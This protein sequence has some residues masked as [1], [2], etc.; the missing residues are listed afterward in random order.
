MEVVLDP[1]YNT[2]YD[3]TPALIKQILSNARQLNNSSIKQSI[4]LDHT[5]TTKKRITIEYDIRTR[6]LSP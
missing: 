2:D 5:G 1:S 3:P 4:T 6:E